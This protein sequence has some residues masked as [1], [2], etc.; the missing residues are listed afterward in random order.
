VARGLRVAVCAIAML[1]VFAA[2]PPVS[3]A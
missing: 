3:E 1:A 2:R